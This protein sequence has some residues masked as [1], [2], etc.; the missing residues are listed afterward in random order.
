MAKGKEVRKPVAFIGGVAQNAGMR[1]A[2]KGVFL[3][4]DDQLVVPEHFTSMG[5]LG[6]IYAVLDE[7]ALK[8]RF[9]GVEKVREYLAKTEVTESHE[10]LVLSERN[11]NIVYEVKKPKEKVKAYPRRRRGL[12]QHECRGHRRALECPLQE[13]PHD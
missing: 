4:E 2:I 6:A 9:V 10:P 13:V 7:P 11:L 1:K 12:H 8:Q 3:L 5:A